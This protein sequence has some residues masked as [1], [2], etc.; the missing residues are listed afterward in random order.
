M[1]IR[2]VA[3]NANWKTWDAKIGELRIWFAP[4]TGLHVDLTHTNH[5]NIPWVNYQ[6]TD[7]GQQG[8]GWYG[9]DPVWYDKHITPLGV[10]YDAVLFVLPRK[11]WKD[12][13]KARGWRTDYDQGPVQLH[14]G[15]DEKEKMQWD[16][17]ENMNAFYQLARHELL[18]AMYMITGQHDMTHFWWDRGQL[19]YA[20]DTLVFPHAYS[21]PAI[22]RALNFIVSQFNK[23]R[24]KTGDVPPNPAP[25]LDPPT[26][27]KVP[28]QPSN[29]ERLYQAAYD[30][31]GIDMAPTENEF[32]CAE[33]LHHVMR[34]AG[35]KGLPTRAIV[36]TIVM[37]RWLQQHMLEIAEPGVKP[38]DIIM[39]PSGTPGA[40]LKNGH[41]G[42]VGKN[43]IMSNN[44]RTYLWDY[45]WTLPE[46]KRY[47]EGQGNIPT[48]YYRWV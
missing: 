16:N 35:V 11:E 27:P 9:I 37:D 7:A 23:I 36:S 3:N 30:S 33:A 5:K 25:P 6:G 2:I 29:R 47:Y 10:G 41:T 12:P 39:S 42:I 14:I 4:K 26:P 15:C 31:L 38:G 19:E 32:G 18:H 40:R 46:W 21:F 20:R 44:S 8:D 48:R 24:E 22:V 34:K 28:K 17:F 13:N 1:R 45:H 43:S